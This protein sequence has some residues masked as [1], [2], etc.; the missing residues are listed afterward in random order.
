MDADGS[1]HRAQD[2]SP[3]LILSA[4]AATWLWSSESTS[5][6]LRDGAASV[7]TW[8]SDGGAE[9]LVCVPLLHEYIL[10]SL[11]AVRFSADNT[12]A[13]LRD[14]ARLTVLGRLWATAQ[15]LCELPGER[16]EPPRGVTPKELTARQLVILQGMSCGLTNAQIALQINFS[17]STVRLESMSIYR[18]FG[19]HSRFEAVEVARK[20]GVL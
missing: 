17:E 6:G 8:R 11:I 14:A 13:L 3:N 12:E 7:E 10:T 19:V 1:L 16:D 4:R 20:A 5:S 2:T 9:A 15:A 18:H